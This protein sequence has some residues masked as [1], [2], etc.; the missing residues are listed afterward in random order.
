MLISILEKD[1]G[2]YIHITEQTASHLEIDLGCTQEDIFTPLTNL[3]YQL[4]Q[5]RKK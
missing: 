1:S 5:R 2:N 4:L 3:F